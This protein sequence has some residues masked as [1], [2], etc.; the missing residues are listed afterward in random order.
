MRLVANRALTAV[1]TV[2]V[3]TMVWPVD[4]VTVSVSGASSG[5]CCRIT[6][7][8]G[9]IQTLPITGAGLYT[10]YNVHLTHYAQTIIYISPTTC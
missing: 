5:Q 7:S 2:A 4:A 3:P 9:T 6:D 8:N 1:T 10:F